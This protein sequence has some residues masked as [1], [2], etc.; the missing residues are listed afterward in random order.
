VRA[1]RVAVLLLALAPVLGIESCEKEELQ[2]LETERQRLL[3]TTVP[4]QEFWDQ[5]GRKGEAAKQLRQA[6]K[7]IADA[8][9]QLA[10]FQASAEPT[11]EA[12]ANAREVNARAEEIRRDATAQ[13]DALRVELHG[14][15]AKLARWEAR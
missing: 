2:A 4:K 11:R 12:I 13:R 8:R 10:G 5:V 7:E 15:E 9:A 3:D 1:L 14:V 6:E